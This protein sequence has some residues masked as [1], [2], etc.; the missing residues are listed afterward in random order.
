MPG[1]SMEPT[2]TRKFSRAEPLDGGVSVHFFQQP[3]LL[4][5]I[6]VPVNGTII[7]VLVDTGATNTFIHEEMLSKLCH[8]TIESAK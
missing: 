3:S 2:R 4:P 1:V 6:R 7:P 8:T 5:F